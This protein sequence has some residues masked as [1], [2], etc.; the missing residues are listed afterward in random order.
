LTQYLPT[1]IDTR[2]VRLP[3]DLEN[4][5]ERLAANIHDLWARR[6][7]EDGWVHG[8]D[9]T[10]KQHPGLVAFPEL[11]DEER[12][13]DRV[14]ATE[15]LKVLLKLG[16]RIESPPTDSSGAAAVGD[17]AAAPLAAA[18]GSDM[19]DDLGA[20][21]GPVRLLE[22]LSACREGVEDPYRRADAA[23]M[24]A[25]TQHR[26]ITIVAAVC[27]TVAILFAIVQL[28]GWLGSELV[29]GEFLAALA[30]LAAVVF[31]LISARQQRWL[32][33]RHKAE[34][35]RFLK[36]G[37]FAKPAVWDGAAESGGEN[38]LK[39][40][41]QQA[42]ALLR[43]T[44]HEMHQ[45][46]EGDALTEMP[47]ERSG[48]G[49]SNEI[50]RGLIAYYL[51]KRLLPQV[52]YFRREAGRNTAND[53]PLRYLPMLC[54]FGSVVCVLL[55]FSIDMGMRFAGI[56]DQAELP[57]G[58]ALGTALVALAAALPAVGAGVRT[59]RGAGEFSR[60]NVR[61]RAKYIALRAFAERLPKEETAA[62]VFKDLW[63]CEQILASE[64]REWLRLMAEVEWYG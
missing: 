55:H 57:R 16:Y 59:V 6:R 8:D 5:V 26:W 52:E 49:V 15:T 60:N 27:G 30:A 50:V 32:L 56:S 41:Q 64:H 14:I 38:P 33:E 45:W 37:L 24:S 28:T 47:A 61:I 46:A 20:F 42:D 18:P 9:R 51:R 3:D 25:K 40:F 1:P 34:R 54:F 12:A 29:I 44:V 13:Y 21:E 31:G 35:Y 58:L 2:Q 53:R 36:F 11:P 19:A 39:A 4:L 23:A 62:A 63:C 10:R 22:V 17:A 48:C 7:L 43:L